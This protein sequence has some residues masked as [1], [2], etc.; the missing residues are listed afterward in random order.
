[1][2]A[3]IETGGKQYRVSSGQKLKIEK[4]AGEA[5]DP[6]SFDKV[7]LIANDDDVKV[8]KPYVS[9]AAVTGKVLRQGRARKV[10]VFKYHS[11]TRY[12]KKKGHRQEFTEV[13]FDNIKS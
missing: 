2:F 3:V 10:I 6:V 13:E 1:M 4:I 7:L 8:G 11:K 9:G 5:G 12:R